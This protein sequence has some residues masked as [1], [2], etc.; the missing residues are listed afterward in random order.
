LIGNAGLYA[1]SKLPKNLEETVL[2]AVA[3]FK[4]GAQKRINETSF[5]NSE[6]HSIN[7]SSSNG[8]FGYPAHKSQV[9]T[10]TENMSKATTSHTPA[11]RQPS[12]HLHSTIARPLEANK[13]TDVIA[14][15]MA[16]DVDI[17]S[18]LYS[19]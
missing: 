6:M 1:K 13:L 10:R 8:K 17:S 2:V 16:E 18:T 11:S 9:S 12:W 5:A 4:V 14:V 15:V 19:R 3:S 7:G